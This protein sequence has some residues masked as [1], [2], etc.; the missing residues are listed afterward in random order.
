MTSPQR[1]PLIVTGLLLLLIL[2]AAL[3]PSPGYAASHE[4]R[5]QLKGPGSLY[6]GPDTM[7]SEAV[8]AGQ[9]A[10]FEVQVV[11][12]GSTLAQY[13]LRTTESGLPADSQLFAGALGLTPLASSPEGYYTQPLQPGKAQ[14]F[15]LKVTM[16]ASSPQGTAIVLL[17]LFAT[18]GTFLGGS[19]ALTEIKAPRYGAS[20]ASVFARQ[21]FQPW[22]GG[23][24]LSSQAT[25]SPAVKP[26]STA[27]FKV[28]LQNDGSAPAA[29][30]ASMSRSLACG[31]FVARDG[32][33]DVT[34]ALL[35]GSYATP[36]LGV[37]EAR[38]LTVVFTR[39]PTCDPGNDYDMA[40]FTAR[41]G[42]GTEVN[43]VQTLA[44]HA[45]G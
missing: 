44:P 40:L 14:T 24:T 10:T 32:S 33:T 45:V 34:A 22:V 12:T 41:N 27:S 42:T 38:T 19:Y 23:S 39:S 36:V 28:K 6:S 35:F 13:N 3:V 20:S 29:I 30:H 11:N 25:T 15:T 21:G 17:T 31:D 1:R 43:R 5:L 4:G 7:I 2:A 16:P 37:H 26:G 18:D 9:T 8:S